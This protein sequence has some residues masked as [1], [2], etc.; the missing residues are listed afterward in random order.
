MR[1]FK[2]IFTRK[3]TTHNVLLVSTIIGHKSNVREL[4]PFSTPLVSTSK[5]K[6]VFN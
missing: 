5:I 4:Y 2:S 1:G 3:V 6:C